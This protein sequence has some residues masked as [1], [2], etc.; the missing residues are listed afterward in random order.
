MQ[1]LFNSFLKLEYLLLFLFKIFI[2]NCADENY[3]FIEA[4]VGKSQYRKIDG[5]I[6]DRMYIFDDKFKD[7]DPEALL[8]GLNLV[9]DSFSSDK[10]YLNGYLEGN[11]GKKIQFIVACK[12]KYDEHNYCISNLLCLKN[13]NDKESIIYNDDK[14]CDDFQ[15][16]KN[17]KDLTSDPDNYKGKCII[18]YYFDDSYIEGLR[19]KITKIIINHNIINVDENP[20]DVNDFDLYRSLIYNN[21]FLLSYMLS[22][23]IATILHKDAYK[24]N[25]VTLADGSNVKIGDFVQKGGIFIPVS[26]EISEDN[27]I[28]VKCKLC[29]QVMVLLSFKTPT[30]YEV[31]DYFSEF[32]RFGIVVDDTNKKNI[33]M[34]NDAIINEICRYNDFKSYKLGLDMN[35]HFSGESYFTQEDDPEYYGLNANSVAISYFDEH[36]SRK[37][38]VITKENENEYNSNLFNPSNEI[39]VEIDL[40]KYSDILKTIFVIATVES[41][42]ERYTVNDRLGNNEKCL[43]IPVQG[44]ETDYT[45]AFYD[46]LRFTGLDNV[47]IEGEGTEKIK[48]PKDFYNIIQMQSYYND[49]DE[50]ISDMRKIKIKFNNNAIGKYCK[51]NLNE[52]TA[53]YDPG[54]DNKYRNDKPQISDAKIFKI[55][56]PNN[57]LNKKSNKKIDNISNFSLPNCCCQ[58]K[59]C[60]CR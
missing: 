24:N 2:I 45:Q 18:F 20:D 22:Q 10:E 55:K 4:R 1:K 12:C 16:Y 37:D 25:E 57:I 39:V 54:M 41:P 30:G 3:V 43:S 51:L 9:E 29:Y 38:I 60:C 35:V 46:Y 17:F 40:G 53:F 5:S 6:Y 13:P 7:K 23:R 31:A 42:D 44:Y 48:I 36:N 34:L 26:Q 47:R 56:I 33:K 32:N 8:R 58:G 28:I 52:D 50:P 27:G 14:Y 59:C 11:K 15:I 49:Q 19:G 21:D